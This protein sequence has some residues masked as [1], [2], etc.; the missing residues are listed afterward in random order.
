DLRTE[1]GPAFDVVYDVAIPSMPVIEEPTMLATHDAVAEPA[2]TQA[3]GG[4]VVAPVLEPAFAP[5]SPVVI[6]RLLTRPGFREYFATRSR[7]LTDLAMIDQWAL[8]LR[9][10]IDYSKQDK[11]ALS[12]QVRSM[13]TAD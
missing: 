7:D 2:H 12:T 9:E 10:Q 5:T 6:D 3:T 13:Y 4:A 1:I 11:E 8:G